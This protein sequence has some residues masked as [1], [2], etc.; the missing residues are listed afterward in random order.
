MV[1]PPRMRIVSRTLVGLIILAFVSA[2]YIPT[3]TA[4]SGPNYW[5]YL[6]IVLL[7]DADDDVP[8]LATRMSP[9]LVYKGF[10]D[11]FH[12]YYSIYMNVAGTISATLSNY[13]ANGQLVLRDSMLRI[14]DRWTRGGPIQTVNASVGVGQYYLQV[15]TGDGFNCTTQYML[16]ASFP[17][18]PIAITAP[19]GMVACLNPPTEAICRFEVKGTSQ[20][21][22]IANGDRIYVFI[23]PVNPNGQGWYMQFPR[24]NVTYTNGVWVQSPSVLGDG[25]RYVNTGETFRLRAAIVR[26]DA[27]YLGV[28]LDQVPPGQPFVIEDI[29]G[30]VAI[31]DV[32]DLIM[33]KR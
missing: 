6:P 24:A 32:S 22:T 23:Y 19:I 14:V 16:I 30:L 10:P 11:D 21:I 13:H 5:L 31:S 9:D 12:D 4:Q 3:T 26:A 15:Y 25:I 29:V 20:G 2:Q 27:T 7:C 28:P 17:P 18:P 33:V 8:G 1:F